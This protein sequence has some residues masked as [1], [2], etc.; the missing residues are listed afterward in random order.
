[1]T[2]KTPVA[3]DVDVGVAWDVASGAR[4]AATA[5]DSNVEGFI[6]NYMYNA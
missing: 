3:G 5:H 2:P 6:C 1:M 4:A